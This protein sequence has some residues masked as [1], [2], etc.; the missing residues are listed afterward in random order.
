M[1]SAIFTRSGGPPAA[2]KALCVITPGAIG[3]HYFR[4][5]AEIARYT[6]CIDFLID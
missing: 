1:I 5:A 6:G 2:V 4:E 3:P